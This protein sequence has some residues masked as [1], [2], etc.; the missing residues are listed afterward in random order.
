MR[1]PA[2]AKRAPRNPHHRSLLKS[3]LRKTTPAKRNAAQ[4]ADTSGTTGDPKG[5]LLK[6]GAVVA[7]VANVKHYL[8]QWGR[9]MGPGDSMLSYLPL[10]HIFDRRVGGEYEEASVVIGLVIGVGWGG[11]GVVRVR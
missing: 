4:T 3:P 1:P 8:S 6:H 5:V 9:D 7:A 2:A 10:A 11:F